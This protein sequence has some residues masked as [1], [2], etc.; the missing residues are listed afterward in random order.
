MKAI[1]RKC[2]NLGFRLIMFGNDLTETMNAIMKAVF[3]QNSSRGGVAATEWGLGEALALTW[4]LLQ[5][6]PLCHAFWK[7]VA[8][9]DPAHLVGQRWI[10][11]C[12]T[13]KYGQKLAMISGL[14]EGE[15]RMFLFCCCWFVVVDGKTFLFLD[16]KSF[17]S[18]LLSLKKFIE[19]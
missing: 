13:I 12:S 6:F 7:P 17:W 3:L 16:L 4:T 19:K 11:L 14:P 1:I 2:F 10:K 5:G 9:H 15:G 18:Q 8:N